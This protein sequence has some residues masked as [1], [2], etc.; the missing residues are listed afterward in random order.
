MPEELALAEHVQNL[1]AIHQLDGPA[2]HDPHVLERLLSL[3]EDRRAP[4]EELHLDRSRDLLQRFLRRDR[5]TGCG[6]AGTRLCR[7]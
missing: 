2:P 5:R 1:T 4:G 3:A 7:A 6:D